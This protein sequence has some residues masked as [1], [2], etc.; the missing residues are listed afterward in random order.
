MYD[1]AAFHDFCEVCYKA[2]EKSVGKHP[3]IGTVERSAP[4]LTVTGVNRDRTYSGTVRVGTIVGDA[5]GVER[6]EFYFGKYDGIHW[7]GEYGQNSVKIARTAPYFW[8]MNTSNYANGRYAV[9][10]LVY[11]T[12]WNV[13]RR[14]VWFTI[15]NSAAVAPPKN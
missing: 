11:D 2:L 6:V 5:S 10:V 8:D 15:K 13:T 1:T 3:K 12:N 7:T 4:T 9:D 14:M